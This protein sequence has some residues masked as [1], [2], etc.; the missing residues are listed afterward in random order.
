M[1]TNCI[2]PVGYILNYAYLSNLIMIQF[3]PYLQKCLKL[4]AC[5][6]VVVDET[7]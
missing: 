3:L 2:I 1:L 7:H 6:T 5:L 4:I